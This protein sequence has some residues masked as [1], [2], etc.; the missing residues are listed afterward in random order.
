VSFHD[1]TFDLREAERGE[2]LRRKH[3]L[4]ALGRTVTRELA[5]IHAKLDRLSE[6]LGVP[7]EMPP[8]KLN[9]KR[10][11]AFTREAFEAADESQRKAV[12]VAFNAGVNRTF[13]QRKE[14]A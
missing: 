11:P 13:S 2:H 10:F 12:R 3:E 1:C 9:P 8:V 7:A 5:A 14:T 4:A 6:M